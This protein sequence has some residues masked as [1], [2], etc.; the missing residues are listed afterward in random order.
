MRFAAA[1]RGEDEQAQLRELAAMGAVH[2]VVARDAEAGAEEVALTFAYPHG[3]TRRAS[4]PRAWLG[5]VLLLDLT[6]G[7]NRLPLP[8]EGCAVE[9]L[10][11]AMVGRHG[12][13]LRQDGDT[14]TVRLEAQEDGDLSEQELP[15]STLWLT[16]PQAPGGDEEAAELS[17]RGLLTSRKRPR[18]A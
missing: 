2:G 10:A 7:E 9:V 6:D 3:R 1:G 11:G 12:R 17:R 13:V 14:C 16:H 5:R 4:A 15:T 18:I 8:R